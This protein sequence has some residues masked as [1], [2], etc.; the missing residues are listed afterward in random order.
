MAWLARLIVAAH[1]I[2]LVVG[3]PPP[4]IPSDVWPRPKYVA[5]GNTSLELGAGF[6]ISCRY[7]G[8][9][10]DPIAAAIARYTGIILMGAP[11]VAHAS[12]AALTA[13]QVISRHTAVL[14][15]GVDESYSLDVPSDGSPAVLS[16]A[17]Q[18]GVLRGLE[19]FAQLVVWQGPDANDSYIITVAPWSCAD[20]P[21][22]PVRGVLIDTAFNFLTVPRIL[23]VLDS[24]ALTKSNMLHW[25]IT[26]EPSWAVQS[27]TYPNF[28]APGGGGPYAAIATYSID[29]QTA[30]VDYAWE[31]GI[32]ILLEFDLPGHAASWTAGNP[33]LV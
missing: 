10:P 30:I 17:N 24:M 16:A 32:L 22:F 13:L 26:D 15:V 4:T 33:A 31:R 6:T 9:C 8:S 28:T 23:D 18:W 29:Q 21:R 14:A 1:L 2:T 7:A 27:A 25:H 19:S 3:L 12:G 20:V 11:A 5:A